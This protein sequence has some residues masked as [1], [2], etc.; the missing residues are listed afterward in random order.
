LFKKESIAYA[1]FK[2]TQIREVIYAENPSI[3]PAADIDLLVYPV[4]LERTV[5]ALIEAGFALDI[6]EQNISHE[7]TLSFK[8]VAID[9]H[10]HILR[11]GR[12]RTSLTDEFLATRQHFDTHIGFN[13]ETTLF[14]MLVHPVFTKY[15]TTYLASLVRMIDLI[16][17]IRTQAI[18]WDM[19]AKLLKKYGVC[20][21]AW[22]T[23]T[24]LEMLTG[25]TLPDLFLEQIRPGRLKC[26]Y[27]NN[28]LL[29]NRS[30]DFLNHP[31]A[32]QLGFTLP[33]HDN[34][35]DA[36]RFLL[37][38]LQEK[39]SSKQKV[40]DLLAATSKSR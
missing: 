1:V 3:R 9:L 33:A 7:V 18:N 15:S 16:Q 5:Q 6:K 13:A 40:E 24:Y 14:I 27:L 31:L 22:I 17:W 32:V 37:T 25:E 2:G 30:S 23:A 38:L 8:N 26:S 28:W 20:T 10:W 36:S 19:L 35:F 34:I 29:A 39:Y 4:D 11:P 12:L 21:A